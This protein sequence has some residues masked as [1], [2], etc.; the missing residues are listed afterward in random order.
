V[1][2]YVQYASLLGKPYRLIACLVLLPFVRSY[3]TVVGYLCLLTTMRAATAS[4]L[5]CKLSI[6][7]SVKLRQFKSFFFR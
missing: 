7:M 5:R 4:N 2:S 3:H 6:I 1:H